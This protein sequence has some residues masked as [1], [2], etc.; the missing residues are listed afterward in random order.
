MKKILSLVLTLVLLA[1]IAVSA[2]EETGTKYDVL[3]VGTT[4][5]F[6]GNFF[7]EAFGNNLS[8]MDVRDL[9]YGYSLVVWDDNAG[10]YIF[11]PR[12]VSGYL[13]NDNPDG[14]RTYTLTLAAD[15]KFSDGTEITAAD[16]AFSFLLESSPE[17]AAVLGG[18]ILDETLQTVRLTDDPLQFS[19]T[20]RSEYT[21]YFYELALLDIYPYPIGVIAPGCAVVDA[22]DGAYLDGPF[23]EEKLKETM[24]GDNGYFTHPS[25]VS[26]AYTLEA[27]DG[28]CARLKI[29][30]FYKGDEA[31]VLPSIGQIEMRT[32]SSDL[33]LQE[34]A[35]GSLD[36]A[37]RCTRAD[38]ITGGMQMISTGEFGMATYPRVGLALI[39]FCGEREP[40]SDPDVRRAVSMCLDKE[41][42]VSEYVSGFGVTVDGHYGLGSWPYLMAAGISVPEESDDDWESLSLDGLTTYKL[43]TEE[44]AK[45]LSGVGWNL[46]A[47]G[48]AY[49]EASGGLR[50]KEISGE[51][52]PLRLTM[53][54]PE[55]NQMGALCE[56]VFAPYLAEAGAELTLRAMPMDQLVECYCGQTDRDCDMILVGYN[57]GKIYDP[58]VHFTEDGEDLYTGI[59]DQEL[60]NRVVELRKTEPGKVFEYVQKWI[61]LQEYRT[62]LAVEI[63]LYS[64]AYF[65]FFTGAL[66][67][68]SPAEKGTWTSAVTKAYLSDYAADGDL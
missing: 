10:C 50:Y 53:V 1:A 68:Y 57:L 45:L 27:Y 9:I 42:L 35:N 30:P 21:P 20:T 52:R 38:N 40:A 56:T 47:D 7:S 32:V 13:V 65:D 63:P 61:G 46:N 33:L 67:D 15:L 48:T 66:Q 36:L 19:I 25:V 5:G 39:S 44:A 16:Y 17:L 23:T 14:S 4:T 49:D 41:S 6:S 43:D 37:V 51:P 59:R 58:S 11:D 22:E 24:L 55:G 31:G 28:T 60:C 34:L 3:K 26:G 29:N 54:Y 8:D 62:A 2:G 64:N 18:K 12:V